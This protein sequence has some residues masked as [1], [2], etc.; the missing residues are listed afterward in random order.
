MSKTT[1]LK[2]LDS[3]LQEV[4]ILVLNSGLVSEGLKEETH[5]MIQE[6]RISVCEC[7]RV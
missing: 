4:D 2:S 5:I 6:I 1:K 3:L 7:V